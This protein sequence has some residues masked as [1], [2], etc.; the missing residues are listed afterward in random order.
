MLS[1]GLMLLFQRAPVKIKLPGEGANQVLIVTLCVLCEAFLTA[2]MNLYCI[3]LPS[4]A[5]M[6]GQATVLGFL[7]TRSSRGSSHPSVASMCESR[8]V[9]TSAS[10]ARIPA[11]RVLTRPWR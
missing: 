3:V 1:A 10:A 5:S 9:S 11:I 7:A 2:E 6:T 8:K 4:M